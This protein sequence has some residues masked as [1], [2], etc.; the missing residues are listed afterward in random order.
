[1][2][3][4]LFISITTLGELRLQMSCSVSVVLL[5]LGRFPFRDEAHASLRALVFSALAFL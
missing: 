4:L 2:L 3:F 5:D 1:M